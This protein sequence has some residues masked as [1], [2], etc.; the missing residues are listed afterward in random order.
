M[1]LHLKRI[2]HKNRRGEC[3]FWE[4]T[5]QILNHTGKGMDGFHVSVQQKRKQWEIDKAFVTVS[6]MLKTTLVAFSEHELPW[7]WLL[8]KGSSG[9]DLVIIACISKLS[10]LVVHIN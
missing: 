4:D 3:A 9:K 7:L 8:L 10:Y 1:P 5:P 6:Q 2:S